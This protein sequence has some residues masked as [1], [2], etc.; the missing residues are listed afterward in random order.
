VDDPKSSYF[1][2]LKQS[3]QKVMCKRKTVHIILFLKKGMDDNP[4]TISTRQIKAQEHMSQKNIQSI[5][6]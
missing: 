2:N 6:H 5:L 4:S 3:V 1:T